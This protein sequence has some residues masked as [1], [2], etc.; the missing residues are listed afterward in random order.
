[1]T[2]ANIRAAIADDP[3][4]APELDEAW[5][6][7]ALLVYPDGKTLISIRLDPDVLAWFRK[8]GKGYQ[9]RMNAVLRAYMQAHR[10]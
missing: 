1:M 6:K 8:K 10:K 5:F 4:A 9:T 7:K 3:D 2:D